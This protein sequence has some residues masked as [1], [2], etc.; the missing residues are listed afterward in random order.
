MRA[1]LGAGVNLVGSHVTPVARPA[2]PPRRQQEVPDGRE[3]RR[4]LASSLT[5][6]AGRG[7]ERGEHQGCHDHCPRHGV[8]VRILKY[9][10]QGSNTRTQ[11]HWQMWA[12]ALSSIHMGR[13]SAEFSNSI[14]AIRIF[15]LVSCSQTLGTAA[16]RQHNP[17]RDPSPAGAICPPGQ[18]GPARQWGSNA[19]Y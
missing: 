12:R 5:S 6:R 2:A 4:A 14:S 7:R 13:F 9:D 16:A 10:G 8:A 19:A 18:P 1:R 17:Q 3:A 11:T 15:C